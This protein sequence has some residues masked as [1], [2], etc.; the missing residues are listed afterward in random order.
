MSSSP[1]KS[2][3]RSTGSSSERHAKAGAGSTASRIYLDYAGFS[4]VDPRV[5]A[6]MRPFM[7]G[8]VSAVPVDREGRLDPHAVA[9]AL[10][11]DT[12]L[13]SVM[14]ANGEIGTLQAVRDIGRAARARGVP[15]H[16]DGVGVVGRLPFS[17]DECLV[18]LL[19]LS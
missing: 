10:R 17:V 9:G 3:P 12:A 1:S 6:F 7:E 4:P 8:G 14:A 19:T 13:V 2:M 11:E 5:V 16:V 18:D 15:F